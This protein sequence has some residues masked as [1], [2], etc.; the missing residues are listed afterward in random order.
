MG[1]WK[2][3]FRAIP[4]IVPPTTEERCNQFF[5][6][7]TKQNKNHIFSLEMKKNMKK[8]YEKKI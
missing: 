8:K 3:R 7:K 1:V 6:L 5:F 2:G 4:G